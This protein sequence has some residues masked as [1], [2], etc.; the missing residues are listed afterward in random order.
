M[1]SRA[2]VLQASPPR[3][4][5]LE[6][7]SRPAS[8]VVPFRH[9][10]AHGFRRSCLG[11]DRPA[12]VQP[13]NPPA[14]TRHPTRARRPCPTKATH[15]REPR[16]LRTTPPTKKLFL[17]RRTLADTLRGTAL[18]LSRHFNLE[19]LER[20]PTNF[21]TRHL[22]Q[23]YTDMLWRVRSTGGGW[24]YMIV[25]LEFQSTVER[26]MARRMLDYTLRI[27][28]GLDPPD[29]GPRK[30][31]PPVLPVVLYNGTRRW[32][33]PTDFRDLFAAVPADVVGY[34]P[35]HRYLLV[36]IPRLDPASLPRDNAFAMIARLEQ[37]RS[38][39]DLERVWRVLARWVKRAE[40]EELLDSFI[41]WI[42]L[43]LAARVGRTAEEI[44]QLIEPEE[45]DRMSTLIERARKWGEEERA[46][47]RLE[48]ER[49]GR[50]EGERALMYH[51]V[52]QRFGRSTLAQVAPVLDQVADSGRIRMV[53]SAVMD[54]DTADEFLA[55][56]T[57]AARG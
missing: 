49:E 17:R 44:D 48:G 41:P 38:A 13:P 50:L 35:R 20:L 22:G 29:L 11:T 2:P 55:R 26:R 30:L 52:L 14:R 12:P 34:L 23:R 16:G 28:D 19:S 10:F 21:V 32:S 27:V 18:N 25:L 9:S 5:T 36:D 42:R 57:E 46:Q 33:A 47:A 4:R 3:T 1:R 51:L 37:V 40:A 7:P 39:A 53:V 54:C 6:D 8:R 15:P 24:L 31:Y 56:A 43:V 45:N